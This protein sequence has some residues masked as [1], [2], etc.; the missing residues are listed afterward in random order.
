MTAAVVEPGGKLIV[1]VVVR[2]EVLGTRCVIE[3]SI[4]R[5]NVKGQQ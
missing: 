5:T 4:F 3:Q 1:K 2:P